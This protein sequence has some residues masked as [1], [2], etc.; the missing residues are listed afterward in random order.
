MYTGVELIAVATILNFDNL[1]ASAINYDILTLGG[2]WSAPVWSAVQLVPG[3]KVF[4]QC[5][6][7]PG[8]PMLL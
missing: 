7:Q 4:C 1:H 3:G 2:S 8:R 6:Q 5:R